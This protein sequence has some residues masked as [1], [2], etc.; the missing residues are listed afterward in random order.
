MVE[1]QRALVARA[2]GWLKP[3]G[4]LVYAVCSL[5]P[6]E[7]EGQADAIALTP[8]P[9]GADELPA[10]LAP[11]PRRLAAH[12]SRHAGRTRRPRRLLHRSLES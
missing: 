9:I 3:G 10:C 8:D 12:R 5:E 11:D 7:G 2:A 4:T 1:L 6:E